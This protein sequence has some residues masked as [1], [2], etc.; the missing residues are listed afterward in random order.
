[1]IYIFKKQ[2]IYLIFFLESKIDAKNYLFAGFE[3]FI[4]AAIYNK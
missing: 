1:M 3:N 2:T 4:Y